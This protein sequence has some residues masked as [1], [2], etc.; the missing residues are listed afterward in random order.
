[1]TELA[2]SISLPGLR[3]KDVEHASAVLYQIYQEFPSIRAE[4]KDV[5]VLT[6]WADGYQIVITRAKPIKTLDDFKGMKIRTAG[7]NPTNLFR[8]LGATPVQFPMP[9]SYLSLD[10]GVIDGMTSPFEAAMS[11]RLY[12]V[13]K[14]MTAAPWGFFFFTCS[15]NKDKWDSLPK[16]I[17]DTITK[18][19]N[20]ENAR[21]LSR[22]WEERAMQDLMQVTKGKVESYVLPDSEVQRLYDVSKPLRE[23]WVKKMTAAGKPDAARILQR[24][25]E[26]IPLTAR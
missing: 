10:K 24:I 8:T 1:M 25:E 23:E 7:M 16:D 18:V 12:E 5:H 22:H 11:F 3:F 17:Q 2:N 6:P 13:T 19:N 20:L 21:M 26:L 15:M 4:F 9:D 14:Y